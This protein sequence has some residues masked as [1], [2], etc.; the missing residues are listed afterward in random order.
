ME[1]GY[2]GRPVGTGTSHD[3]SALED[4]VE[5]RRDTRPGDIPVTVFKLLLVVVRSPSTGT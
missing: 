2:D 5:H 4:A 3:A 1:G